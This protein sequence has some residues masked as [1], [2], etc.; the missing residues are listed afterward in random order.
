MPEKLSLVTICREYLRSV[1]AY[2]FT[3]QLIEYCSFLTRAHLRPS[4]ILSVSSYL[5]SQCLEDFVFEPIANGFLHFL[6]LKQCNGFFLSLHRPYQTL[7]H[8]L[9]LEAQLLTL[10]FLIRAGSIPIY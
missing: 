10:Y 9:N 7:H 4:D 5:F 2:K 6:P 8:K 3:Y 1:T